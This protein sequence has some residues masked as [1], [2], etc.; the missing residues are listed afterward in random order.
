MSSACRSDSRPVRLSTELQRLTVDQFHHQIGGA[1]LVVHLGLAIVVHAGDAGVV[2]HR[3][4][5]RLNPESLDELGVRG[6]F[7]LEHLDRDAPAQPAVHRLPHLA[8]AAG[9]DQAL[10]AISAR[11][12]H[13]YSRAHGPPCSAASMTARPIGAAS[14]PPVADSRSAPSSTSTATATF[15]VL[16]GR[17]SDVPRVRWCV[18]RVGAVLCGTSL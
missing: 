4:G 18:T 11:Q 7:L 1:T 6:E 17:E 15:G 13:T 5:A 10:Q 16:R 3:G 9:G 14:A 2:E 8:H 12:R